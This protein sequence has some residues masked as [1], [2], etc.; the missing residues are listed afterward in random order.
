VGLF[1]KSARHKDST[2]IPRYWPQ[3]HYRFARREVH[4]TRFRQRL[5]LR[6]IRRR[7]TRLGSASSIREFFFFQQHLDR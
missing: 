3:E 5:A 6:G 1:S 4:R 7:R 2:D